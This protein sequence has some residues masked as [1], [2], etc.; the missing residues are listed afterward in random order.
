MA[1]SP[2]RNRGGV[3]CPSSFWVR[4][5]IVLCRGAACCARTDY[6]QMA[7]INADI[8]GRHLTGLADLVR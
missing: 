3:R 5:A 2:S 8:L 7:Q 4:L 1:R 6:P